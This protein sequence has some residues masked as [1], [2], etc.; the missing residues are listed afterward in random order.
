MLFY[1]FLPGEKRGGGREKKSTRK[2][3]LVTKSEIERE[4]G[5][6][7]GGR[8]D[9]GPIVQ[10]TSNSCGPQIGKKDTISI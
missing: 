3:I 4:R 10:G 2:K 9:Y 8:T 5:R 7:N 1:L 6:C